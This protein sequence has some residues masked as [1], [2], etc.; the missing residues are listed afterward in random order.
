VTAHGRHPVTAGRGLGDDD[1]RRLRLIEIATAAI[2]LYLFA[3][4][5]ASAIAG[6][7][8]RMVGALALAALTAMACA[9]ARR[10]RLAASEGMTA[11]L[12]AIGSVVLF[13]MHGPASSRLGELQLGIVFL[14]LAGQRWMA[15]A[16]AALVLGCLFGALATGLPIPMA[17]STLPAWLRTVR[18][19]ALCT[20]LM[21][22]FTHGYH[23]LLAKLVRRTAELDA[24]LV[25][26]VTAR[27]RLERLVVKRTAALGRAMADLETF[28]SIVSHDLRAPLRHVRSFL[29]LFTED[30]QL[31]EARLARITAAQQATADLL[32]KLEA[33]LTSSRQPAASG[34][35]HA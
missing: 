12:I 5:C 3:T 11:G 32:A 34:A 10:R 21:M 24:A 25:E 30:C 16:Q 27:D 26:L 7:H 22:L 31:G 20:T 15:P 1:A 6:D 23:G 2:A 29:A 33:V 4:A 18:E 19:I 9:L 14:G 35:P 13:V 28:T 8:A 17:P